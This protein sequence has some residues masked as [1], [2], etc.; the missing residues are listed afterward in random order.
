MSVNSKLISLYYVY[1]TVNFNR[2]ILFS[3]VTPRQWSGHPSDKRFCL[4]LPFIFHKLTVRVRF[5]KIK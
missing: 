2:G 5:F 1:L 4:K 3:P